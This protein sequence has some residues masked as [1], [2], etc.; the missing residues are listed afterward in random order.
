MTQGTSNHAAVQELANLVCPETICRCKHISTFPNQ[1]CMRLHYL[2]LGGQAF[3][4]MTVL[5]QDHFY[6]DNLNLHV[7]S[8]AIEQ[9]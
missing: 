4:R 9:L 8:Q 2:V 3:F 5:V 6:T 1:H 7:T